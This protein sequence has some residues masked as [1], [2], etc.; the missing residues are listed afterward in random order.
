M[1]GVNPSLPGTPDEDDE[2]CGDAY[3]HVDLDER[4]L[5][6]ATDDDANPGFQADRTAA[7][8]I[9]S[10]CLVAEHCTSIPGTTQDSGHGH[11]EGGTI[12]STDSKPKSLRRLHARQT[13]CDRSTW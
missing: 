12:G 6:V 1:R 8:S 10:Q 4:P 2:E 3:E 11:G 9:L 13:A 7:S 5:G